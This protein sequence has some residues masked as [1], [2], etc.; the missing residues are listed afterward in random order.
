MLIFRTMQLRTSTTSMKCGSP[1]VT[2][3]TLQSI[4]MA[5]KQETR[6]MFP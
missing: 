3:L 2:L 6:T 1:L 5:L 4:C